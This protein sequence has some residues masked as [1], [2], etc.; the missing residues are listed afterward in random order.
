MRAYFLAGVAAMMLAG[1]QAADE[2]QAAAT[3]EVR[4]ANA[5]M[6]DVARLTK[7]ARAKTVMQPG[8]WRTE[9]QVVAADLSGF[10]EGQVRDA[11]LKAIKGQERAAT[12]CRTADA[13]K[14]L[15]IDNLEQVAGTCTFPRY[16]QA[17]GRIDVE[18]Q[19]N[20]ASKTVLVASGALSPTGYDVTIQ[21]TSGTKGA[22]NYLGLTLR[23]KG[24]RIGNCVAKA[25]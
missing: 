17:G 4:L 1:C 21:Q 9:L 20:G 8:Q 14:P 10:P 24:E 5:S 22:A 6:K 13:L 15:D 19:C 2:K 3:G 16:I 12:G 18:I 7:A 23:A 25:G 11:Q